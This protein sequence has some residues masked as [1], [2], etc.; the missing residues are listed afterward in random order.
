MEEKSAPAKSNLAEEVSLPEVSIFSSMPKKNN[1]FWIIGVIFLLIIIA[2]VGYVFVSESREH[3]MKSKLYHVGILSC[4]DYFANISEGFKDG[5]T[6]LG[7]VEGKDIVYDIHKLPTESDEETEKVLNKFVTE[8]VDLIVVAPTNTALKAKS[9]TRGTNIPVIFA[10]AYTEG[11][12][13]VNSVTKP[14]ENITGMRWPSGAELAVK[15][16]EILHEMIPQIKRLWLGYE[17]DYPGMSDRMKALRFA[18]KPLGITLVEV[19][20]KSVADINT[21][22]QMREKL[23]D[24]GIDAFMTAGFSFASFKSLEMFNQFAVKHGLPIVG[25]DI[26]SSIF[27]L[28]P[29]PF[30][31]AKQVA[32]L[33]DKVFRGIPAGTMPVLSSESYLEINYKIIQQLKININ[34]SLLGQADKIIR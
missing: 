8:K 5:M 27:T 4:L 23:K 16:L 26:S 15:K 24:I 29:D 7:Y 10:S 22:L 6:E 3:A 13:L 20:V 1:P 2:A 34:E 32:Y 28:N 21:D 17:K 19:P 33:A 12:N 14:G 18:A 25:P 9:V 30:R 31:S 11:N